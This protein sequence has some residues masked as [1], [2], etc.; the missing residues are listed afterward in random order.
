MCVNAGYCFSRSKS[1]G[2]LL[3]LSVVWRLLRL[4]ACVFVVQSAACGEVKA[5]G[6]LCND[7]RAENVMYARHF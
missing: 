1:L 4:S 3:E 7:S 2:V 5:D 6:V